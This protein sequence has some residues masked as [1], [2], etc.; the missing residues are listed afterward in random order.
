MKKTAILYIILAGIGWGTS[1]IFL[2]GLVAYGFTPMQTTTVRAIIAALGFALYILL[3]DRKSF[4]VSAGELLLFALGGAAIYGTAAFYFSSIEASSASTAVVLMYTAPVI[5]MVVSVAFLGERFNLA[6]LV[7]VALV[8][9]G[10]ALVSGIIGGLKFSVFGIVLGLL[11][12][13]AYSSYNLITRIQMM[14]GMSSTSST[15]YG[16]AFMAVI[17]LIVTSPAKTLD[18]AIKAIK[19]SP[20]ALVL[21]LGIGVVTCILPYL[22][23]TLALKHLPAGTASSLAVVEP[24]AATLFSVFIFGERLDLTS[25]IG[26]IMILSAVLI[27]SRSKE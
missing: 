4:K 18:V 24:V 15:L 11:A 27:L 10:C 16:F 7:S 1:G 22:F 14:K 17:S 2:K 5:V 6:K 20:S 12:G 3:T 26:I 25:V 19:A 23:Y 13:I 8:T 9:V 21:M